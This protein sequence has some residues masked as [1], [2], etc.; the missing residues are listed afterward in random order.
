M[1]NLT[2]KLKVKQRLNKLSS[3]DYSNIHD[4]QI[5]EAFNKASV[6]WSRR[7]IVGSNMSK[8]GDEQ[9]VRRIDDLQVLLEDLPITL[10]KKEGFYQ[11][12]LPADYFEWKRV[13]AKAFT[14]DCCENP[15][16]LI[17]YLGEEANLDLLLLDENR[18]PS[19]EWGETFST[20]RGNFL[21]IFTNDEFEITDSVLTYYK[22]PRKIEFIGSSNPTTGLV[23][24]VDVESE[25]KDDVV[26]LIIDECVKIISGDIEHYGATQTASNSVETNN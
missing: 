11:T 13:S 6:S 25:F 4:W 10:D 26:E 2:V 9:T 21:K 16:K 18:K 19:F 22:Q 3:D 24:T 1:N 14:E 5:A 12:I 7:Q 20:M 23:S 17:I 15:R 8:T